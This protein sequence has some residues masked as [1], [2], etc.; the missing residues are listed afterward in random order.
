MARVI[1]ARL[2]EVRF[3]Q[4]S[5]I[6]YPSNRSLSAEVALTKVCIGNMAVLSAIPSVLFMAVTAELFR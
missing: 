4:C 3:I 1:T 5:L 6:L 2:Y